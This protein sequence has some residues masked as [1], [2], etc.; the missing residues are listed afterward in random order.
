MS[1]LDLRLSPSRRERLESIMAGGVST[2]SVGSSSR[3]GL[4]KAQGTTSVGFVRR[5][6]DLDENTN[7]SQKRFCRPR[8]S[9]EPKKS[10]TDYFHR[11]PRGRDRDDVEPAKKEN[12][13]IETD[14][15][16]DSDSPLDTV[17]EVGSLS[18]NNSHSETNTELWRLQHDLSK[19]ISDL[20]DYKT[21]TTAVIMQLLRQLAAAESRE[22]QEQL[23]AFLGCFFSF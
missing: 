22:R 10:I 5:R 8:P 15:N 1:D 12:S 2:S 21:R 3:D 19:A 23:G 14:R 7:D 16:K 18:R 20:N 6:L 17:K 13:V 9:P 11:E 4:P